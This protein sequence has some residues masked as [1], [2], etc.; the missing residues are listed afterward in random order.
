MKSMLQPFIWITLL[1]VLAVALVP[2][3][4]GSASLRE[5]MFLIWLFVIFASSLNMITGYTG[6]TNFGHII[7]FGVG[8]YF[9]FY[10]VQSLQI[11]FVVA[12]VIGGIIASI[13]AVLLGIPMLRLRGAYFALGTIGLNEAFRAFFNNFDLFG[14]S[15]G[16]FF[17]ATVF[18]AYGG[19]TNALWMAY[20][21]IVIIALLTI[22]TSYIVKKSKFGL[23]LMAIREDQDAAQVIGI[24]PSRYKVM[25]YA[26]SAFFP[27]LAGGTYFFKNSVIEPRQAFDLLRS[28]EGLVMIMLGGYGTVSGPIIGAILYERLRS[29]LI[30]APPLVFMGATITF[31]NL[32]LA[33]AGVLL[34]LIVLFVTS[35]VVGL[36]RQY[37]P[38]LRR[39]L[40]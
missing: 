38:F 23:G 34:L 1:I 21:V 17:N 37:V 2:A 19:A 16:M 12:A 13:V 9:C 15:I 26:I 35:G 29:L 14:G 6:Y 36:L 4:T 28:I 10:L 39:Y 40:E 33:I 8:G 7:F 22:A 5:N 30:T 18:Q 3:F 24:N 25:A 20:Y 11:H 32:H 27:A 31:S